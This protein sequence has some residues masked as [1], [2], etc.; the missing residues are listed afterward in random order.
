MTTLLLGVRLAMRGAR[1]R[2]AVTALALAFAVAFLLSVLGALPARQAKLDRLAA[3][4]AVAADERASAGHAAPSATTQ[5]SGL[6]GWW[7]GQTLGGYRVVQ[8][9]QGQPVPPG[10][11][12]LPRPGELVVSPALA[13]AL[14]GT[15]GAE[16][17]PRLPGRVVGEIAE[18]GLSGPRELYA[19]V[20]VAQAPKQLPG[21]A[22]AGF[23]REV[24]RAGV[25]P[26]LRVAAQLGAVGLLLPVL[27]LVATASRL[28]AA[29]RDRRLAAVRLVGGSP[30]QVALLVSGEALLVGAFGAAAGLAVFLALRPVAARL[31]PVAG[32]VFAGDLM[33]PAWQVAGSLLLV[34]LG[35]LLVSLLGMRRLVIDPLGVRRSGR[36]K[37]RAG[38]WRLLP[39]TSGLALL[40]ALWVRHR[41]LVGVDVVLLL[42]GGALTLLGLAVIAPVVSRLAGAGLARLP[43]VAAR[44]AGRRLQADPSATSRTLTGTVLVVFV[45]TWLLAFLPILSASQSS[46]ER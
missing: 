32:G 36:P 43:G 14:R 34:P 22:A 17:A 11:R 42:G 33:A 6:Y 3:R 2:V 38:L 7:R 10:V 13:A 12:R 9:R 18:E 45:G 4:A 30:R 26:E 44:L 16:L 29:T 1:V 39:L 37:G 5:L 15:H 40:G 46:D 24:H 20:G 41:D 8:A 35:A 25:G 27:V 23:G 31:V 28:S 21:F 19:Y